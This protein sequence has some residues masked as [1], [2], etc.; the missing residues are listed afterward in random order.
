[1][2][3]F[4]SNEM[5]H[6][7]LWAAAGIILAVIIIG[8]ALSVPHTRDVPQA[9]A[10][11]ASSSSVPAVTVRDTFKKGVH[12]ITGSVTAPNACANVSAESLLQGDALTTESILLN[13]SLS[14]DVGVCL[15]L[16]TQ[17]PFQATLSAPANVPL[18]VT[19]NGLPATTSAP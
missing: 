4:F 12:T 14:D 8:F 5:G 13:I 16:P 19:V 17:M 9:L 1:M 11:T 7:R 10:P 3:N 18:A 6:R 15:E 2:M